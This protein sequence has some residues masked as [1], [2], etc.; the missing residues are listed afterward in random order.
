MTQ[1]RNLLAASDLSAPSRHALAR[2]AMIA[3]DS[4]ANL[5]LLHVLRAGL[6]EPLQ[7]LLGS[8]ADSVLARVRDTTFQELGQLAS[9][10]CEPLSVAPSLRITT[11]PVIHD[12]ATEA[13]AHDA[14]LVVLGARGMGFMRH[15]LLGSIAERMLR[16]TLRPVL[17]V[18]QLP[19]ERYQRVLVP[20]DFS[21]YSP[22][23]VK[24]ARAVAPRAEIILLHA[25]DNSQEGT[26]RYA[27]VDESVIHQ[28]LTEARRAAME[29]LRRL[30]LDTGLD[31]E[32]LQLQ[33]I[34]GHP[35]TCILEQEE[36]KDVDLI[37][38]GK[39][40]RGV[41]E[42]LLLGS[43]SKHVLAGARGDVLVVR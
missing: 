3:R 31:S 23:A 2:A 38:I 4:G 19:H 20:V 33:A 34:N 17:V 11:G 29:E 35:S 14:D 40:G 25:F 24:M 37:V 30:A 16:K 10:V 9:D 27:G 42:E 15:L 36:E 43:V 18:K 22:L 8:D 21:T 41:S 6:P 32:R 28:Y 39:H 7:R 26:L 1:L 13:D 5:R 12:I